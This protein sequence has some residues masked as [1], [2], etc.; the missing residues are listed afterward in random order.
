VAAATT[1]LVDLTG[2]D[3]VSGTSVF[4]SSLNPAVFLSGIAKGV[5]VR[6]GWGQKASAFVFLRKNN[7]IKYKNPIKNCQTV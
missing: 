6:G 7:H 2:R 4:V 3:S 5:L 1:R